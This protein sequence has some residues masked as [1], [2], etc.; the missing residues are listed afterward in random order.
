M[1]YM[2]DCTIIGDTELITDVKKTLC[3][4]FTMKDLREAKSLLRAKI[5]HDRASKMIALQQ[6]GHIKGILQDFGME[7][8]SKA[9]TPIVPGQQLPK[10]ERTSDEDLKL[11]YRSIVGK[12]AFLSH[13][14]RPDI[15]FAI[16][17]LSQHLNGWNEEHWRAMKHM[18]C[19]LQGMP[20]YTIVYDGKSYIKG[21]GHGAPFPQV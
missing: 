1:L 18:L 2:D 7:N 8:C 14:T 16:H 10:L 21:Q 6:W 12:L 19:Y 4:K 17:K 15:S 3:T 13:T 9:V 11:P 20:D 5:L